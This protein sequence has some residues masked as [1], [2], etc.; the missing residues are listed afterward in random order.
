[1]VEKN[2]KI[3]IRPCNLKN[4]LFRPTGDIGR[5]LEI[6]NQSYDDPWDE[7]TIS[8]FLKLSGAG[9]LVLEINEELIGFL[10]FEVQN[11]YLN[12]VSIAIDPEFRRKGYATLLIDELLKEDLPDCNKIYCTISDKNLGAHL[13]FNKFGFS[14]IK[15]IKDF[16]SEGH[17]AYEFMYQ[18]R[19]RKRK[20]STRK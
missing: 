10:L 2:P 13:F 6:E 8:Y 11:S 20:R 19:K 14:A 1:M 16:F 18:I 4:T 12:L 15:I 5:I 17:D 7:N 3:L 9:S